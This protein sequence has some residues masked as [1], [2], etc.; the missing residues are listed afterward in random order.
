LPHPSGFIWHTLRASHYLLS[1]RERMRWLWAI[2]PFGWMVRL[3]KLSTGRCHGLRIFQ[4]LDVIQCLES[5]FSAVKLFQTGRSLGSRTIAL[6]DLSPSCHVESALAWP[7][8]ADASL[9]QPG[10][11]S[12]HSCLARLRCERNWQLP[13]LAR[14]VSGKRISSRRVR[15]HYGFSRSTVG[16]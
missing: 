12:A 11:L 2:S 10:R 14:V 5:I 1:L 6:I 7:S 15:E 3:T 16:E 13:V 4:Y 8:R 9:H